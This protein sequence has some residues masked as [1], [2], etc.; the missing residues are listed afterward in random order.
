MH[1]ISKAK[2]TLEH[3]KTYKS[4]IKGPS[5][6]HEPKLVEIINTSYMENLVRK[7]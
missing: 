2:T 4:V 6:I 1:D 3:I 5:I 7:P